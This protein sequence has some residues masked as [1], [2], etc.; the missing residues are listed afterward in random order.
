MERKVITILVVLTTF[1]FANEGVSLL[2]WS[3]AREGSLYI[4]F[5][6]SNRL[7]WLALVPVTALL[8]LYPARDLLAECGLSGD[9][10]AATK[11]AAIA[12]LP[13]LLGYGFAASFQLSLS[14]DSILLGAVVAAIAEEIYFRG[15]L[16]GQLYRRV[17]LW[18]VIA[19]GSSAI[20]FGVAHLYQGEGLIETAGI[21][22]VTL[23]GGLW[24]SWL[25]MRWNFNLWV[26]INF[27]LLMNL[28]W[29]SFEVGNNALGGLEA[30]I[31]RIIT[32]GLSI[33]LTLRWTRTPAT[34]EAFIEQPVPRIQE[35]ELRVPEER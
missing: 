31:Y 7:F 6:A 24:F 22:A 9:F 35:L 3:G 19:A 30:N 26:P 10:K 27:H 17:G 13:M 12:T 32:I 5:T 1:V 23:I 28:Y 2:A 11:I 8:L 33:W 14:L 21:F 16:F 18:F 4:L 34:V 25:Y 15:F 29:S 20:L